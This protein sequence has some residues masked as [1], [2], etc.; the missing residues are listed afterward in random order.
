MKAT[1]LVEVVRSLEHHDSVE[2][3]L[4][5]AIEAGLIDERQRASYASGLEA[6]AGSEIIEARPVAEVPA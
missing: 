5:A 4:D 2:L 3:A 1:G 6:L